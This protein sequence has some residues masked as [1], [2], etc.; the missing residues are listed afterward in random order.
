MHEDVADAV[1][2]ELKLNIKNFYENDTKNSKWYGR[3][4][5]NSAYKRLMK[6]VNQDRHYMVYGGDNDEA[7]LYIEPTIFDFGRDF[8]AFKNSGCMSDELFGPLIPIFRYRDLDTEVL[9][10]VRGGEKPLALYCFTTDDSVGEKMMR[11][12]SSG[13]AC[14]N[15]VCIHLGNS[16]LPFG[17]VGESGM[18]NYLF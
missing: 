7:E 13:G 15:D 9:P 6:Y 4:I 18:G 12:T 5:N 2:E 16:E 1:I 11:L 14:V 10:F 8:E 17:G 3:L